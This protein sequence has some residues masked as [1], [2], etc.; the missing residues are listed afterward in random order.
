MKYG[1]WTAGSEDEC[2]IRAQASDPWESAAA[3]VAV[4]GR[5]GAMRE[6]KGKERFARGYEGWAERRMGSRVM[7][8]G[9]SVGTGSRDRRK[10]PIGSFRGVVGRE[11]ARGSKIA[12][13][14]DRQGRVVPTIFQ[15]LS[16]A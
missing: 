15:M 8:L 2:R 7:R 5:R 16:C 11:G 13:Y 1:E 3:A 9:H 12:T 14:G 6:D 4:G 10:K